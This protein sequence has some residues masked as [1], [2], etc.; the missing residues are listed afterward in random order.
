MERYADNPTLHPL[1]YDQSLLDETSQL[2]RINNAERLFALCH[3]QD[4]LDQANQILIQEHHRDSSHCIPSDANLHSQHA[5]VYELRLSNLAPSSAQKG[6]VPGSKEQEQQLTGD[7]LRR[8]SNGMFTV[9]VTIHLQE[10]D[11]FTSTIERASA[12]SIQCCYELWKR[13]SCCDSIDDTLRSDLEPFLN[14]FDPSKR[15]NETMNESEVSDAVC[16]EETGSIFGSHQTFMTLELAA[17]YIHFCHAVGFNQS[18]VISS[19]ELLSALID[20]H[21]NSLDGFIDLQRSHNDLSLQ[22]D[23]YGDNDDGLLYNH[24]TDFLNLVYVQTLPRIHGTNIRAVESITDVLFTLVKDQRKQSQNCAKLIEESCLTFD[25]DKMKLSPFPNQISMEV[26]CRNIEAIIVCDERKL[27][28]YLHEAMQDT[29]LDL[30]DLTK[31]QSVKVFQEAQLGTDDIHH[32]PSQQ[33]NSAVEDTTKR[34]MEGISIPQSSLDEGNDKE[35]NILND[36]IDYFWESEDR[37]LNRGKAVAV[38]FL[39]YTAWKR[40]RHILG[41]ARGA[42]KVLLSPVHEIVNAITPSK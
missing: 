25:N 33:I 42:G 22:G 5:C 36:A 34:L 4:A 21:R 32:H 9:S 17:L 16:P 18:A 8:E 20:V 29:L 14:L 38:G 40:R 15:S 2:E 27:P 7:V 30:K 11:Q 41:G 39:T 13:R 28:T 10:G 24:C 19:L 6:R 3:F 1:K 12:V 23:D 37:W 31:Q 26:I 35:G